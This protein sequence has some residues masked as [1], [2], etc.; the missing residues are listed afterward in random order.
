MCFFSVSLLLVL[1][2]SCVGQAL[3]GRIKIVYV[4]A[5]F[6]MKNVL[7]HGREKEVWWHCVIQCSWSAVYLSNITKLVNSHNDYE[8]DKKG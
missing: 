7:R 3:F 8:E 5:F 4:T 1:L 2:F 6:L